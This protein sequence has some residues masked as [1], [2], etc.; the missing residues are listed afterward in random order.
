M[1]LL[2]LII[3]GK[4]VAKREGIFLKIYFYNG[5]SKD[6]VLEIFFENDFA[7]INYLDGSSEIRPIEEI[8]S[9]DVTH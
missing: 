7:K 2:F 9:I 5:R 3:R 6:K 8:R 1:G 4:S